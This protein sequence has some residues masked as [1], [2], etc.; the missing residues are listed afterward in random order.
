MAEQNK[1]EKEG[2][3]LMVC[4]DGSDSAT[5]AYNKAIALKK[6]HDALYI[7]TIVQISDPGYIDHLRKENVDIADSYLR[8]LEDAGKGVCKFYLEDCKVKNITNCHQVVIT[9]NHAK[10][11]LTRFSE[12]KQ[13]DMIF[14][15][16]RGLSKIQ[17][18][19]IGSFSQ[20]ILNHSKCDVVLV[21]T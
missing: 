9:S 1:V 16:P 17:Q 18:L 20:Y 21:R 13:I 14:V 15:A 3:N 12:E 11:E 4:V 5:K 19:F 2:L 10:E 7:C 8:A 6:D